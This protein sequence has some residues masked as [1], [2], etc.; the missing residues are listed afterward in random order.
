MRRKTRCIKRIFC[1]ILALCVM[2]PGQAMAET[3]EELQEKQEALRQENEELEKKL[4]ALKADEAQALEYQKTLEEKIRVVEQKVDAAREAITA[5]DQEITVAEATLEASKEEYRDT[6]DTFSQR[7][8]ALYKTGS[9]STLEILLNARSFSDFAMKT[10][11]VASISKHDQ[12]LLVKIQEYY[13]KTKDER[14]HLQEMRDEETAIKKEQEAAQ[15]E[16]EGLYAE[17]DALIARLQADEAQAQATIRSNEE[18]DEDLENQI[19]ELIK[20]R[21]EAAQN[22][23]GGGMWSGEMTPGMHDGFSPCWPLPGVSIGS[24]TGHFGDIYDN[25]PHKGLDIGAGYGTPIVAAQAGQVLSA[26]FHYSWG[27]NVLIWHNGTF[28]TRYAHCSSLAVSPGQYVEQGQVI[29]YVGS[30]G[31]SFGNHLH[32]EVY[33]DGVRVNPDPYLGIG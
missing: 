28:S 13:D 21:N 20:K 17:N 1:M 11:L 23:G 27:N 10:Q 18:E 2:I 22:P 7:L 3:I 16:L 15:A 4:D 30:T 24:I 19:G 14:A 6:I 31:Y 5:L 25:G 12:A 9:V 33:Y 26:E 8:K 29:G 32:F